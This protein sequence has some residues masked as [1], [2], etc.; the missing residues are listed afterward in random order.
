M[1][2]ISID[3]TEITVRPASYDGFLDVEFKGSVKNNSDK[4]W[5][6]L[7]ITVHLLNSEKY[8]VK[9]NILYEKVTVKPNESFTFKTAFNC[10]PVKLLGNTPDCVV[11]ISACESTHLE[12]HDLVLP[13]EPYSI[14][15]IK[16]LC[17]SEF[18]KVLKAGIWKGVPDE[19]R[20]TFVQS[21]FQVQLMQDVYFP[22]VRLEVDLYER[23]ERFIDILTERKQAHGTEIISLHAAGHI[24]ER[25]LN[26]AT[27]KVNIF[28]YKILASSSSFKQ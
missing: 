4:T 8:P 18:I 17:D 2:Q 25:K 27:A 5:D 12:F 20:I 3:A 11:H 28:L 13:N 15:E 16:P 9:E 21:F 6:F 1:N 22:Q 23:D 19:N 10:V 14:A 26:Q 7:K 24:K